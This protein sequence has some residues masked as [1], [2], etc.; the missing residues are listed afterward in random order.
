MNRTNFYAPGALDRVSHL[1]KDEAWLRDRLVDP[2][3]RFTSVWKSQ[4]LVV[5]G[6]DG[7]TAVLARPEHV[8]SVLPEAGAVI[9]LGIEDGSARFA[10][11]LPPD[12]APPLDRL[13][14]ALDEATGAGAT[15]PRFQDLRAVGPLLPR[16]EGSLLAY[17]RGLINWHGRHRFCG[18]CGSPTHSAEG[19]HVRR[20][21]NPACATTHFPRTDP[22]VIMLVTSGDRALLGRQAVWA[23]GMYSTLAGFVEP[24]ESL[25]AAVAREVHEEA[26]VF[27][28]DVRYHS[29][30]PWPF[31]ASIMLGF[32]ATALSTEI[33]VD[34]T[35]IEDARWFE[36]D[37]LRN[38]QDDETF[39][40]P[41][42]DSIARRL[43]EDWLAQ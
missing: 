10:I 13:T 31:P 4:H 1:R 12:E 20:C 19:G 21:A 38:H 8:V 14:A 32:Y 35:E 18:V 7:P 30:Q 37:W 36:R 22:A 33:K 41:R 34:Q 24:G 43:I 26:G 5:T 16:A 25:E 42:T 28:D 29:S 6:P 9:F 2:T 15:E 27:V 17:A 11:D 23:K 39:R 40:L 3:S